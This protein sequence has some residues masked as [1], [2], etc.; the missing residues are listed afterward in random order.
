[1]LGRPPRRQHRDRPP[2]GGHRDPFVRL[3]ENGG[4]AGDRVAQDREALCRPDREG[5]E[6][7]EVVEAALERMLECGAL[8]Q[9]PCEVA[10]GDLGVV[11]GLELDAL[12]A[13]VLAQAVVVRER[14]VVHE[15]EV[16]ARRE[17]M[18]ALGRDTA[19]GRHTRM[20]E[21]VRAPEV[22][23]PEGLR[24]LLGQTGLLVDL[25]D[26]PRAHHAQVGSVGP[27]P[28]LGLGCVAID[29]EH[30][31]TGAHRRLRAGAEDLAE[32]VTYGLP[33]LARLGR[34]EGQLAGAARRRVA[35]DGDA[36]RVGATARHLDEHRGEMLAELLLEQGGLGEEADDPAH[37]VSISTPKCRISPFSAD[38]YGAFLHIP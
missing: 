32:A 18:R 6:T 13:E 31:V 35:V 26:L 16:V 36:G 33:P 38:Q 25:D 3:G 23:E 24:E 17:R 14:A 29:D 7:V 19:L 1:M 10:G 9:P 15:A 21:R 2:L 30:G 22:L 27:H 28:T 20:S 4:L 5:V 12:T 34:V 37:V 11:L 8:A